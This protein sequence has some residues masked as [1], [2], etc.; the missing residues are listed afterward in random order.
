[1]V[2]KVEET[3]TIIEEKKE[4]IVSPNGENQELRTAKFLKSHI[5]ISSSNVPFLPDT[6]WP[7]KVLFKGWR[8]PQDK[9]AEWVELLV[10]KHAYLWN[11][12]GICDAILNSTY[13]I[14]KHK[15]IVLG[16]AEKW[17]PETNTF[18]FLWGEATI[19]LEDMLILGGFSV[20]GEPVTSCLEG[21]LVE[22]KEKLIKEQ[23]LFNKEKSKKA[24]YPGWINRFMGSN[25]E[26]EHVA[27]LP[28]WMSRYVFPSHPEGNIGK[29][30]FP[31]AI[32]L[33]RGTCVALAPAVLSSLYKQLRLMKEVLPDSTKSL[34]VWGPFQIVQLWDWEHF[35]LL[36]PDGL[37]PISPGAPRM[38]QWGDLKSKFKLSD[39]RTILNS[40]EN[41][42]WRPYT[43]DL[44][45]WHCP[46][47]YKETDELLDI[48]AENEELKSFPRCL[49]ACELVGLQDT[50]EQY[51]P[52]RV[53]MQ[54]GYDQ[55]I[56]GHFF[57]ENATW[58]LAWETYNKPIKDARLYARSRLFR[59]KVSSRYYAWWKKS[60]S[61]LED[62]RNVVSGRS[63]S[64]SAKKGRKMSHS[65]TTGSP[66]R[67]KRK[68]RK[69]KNGAYKGSSKKSFMSTQ[70]QSSSVDDNLPRTRILKFTKT[71]SG[72]AERPSTPSE[73]S[74]DDDNDDKVP[75]SKL[76][77]GV[78]ANDVQT[79]NAPQR[80]KLKATL[81][82][83]N[84]AKEAKN[85]D[86]GDNPLNL[87]GNGE[88]AMYDPLDLDEYGKGTRYDP[89]DADDY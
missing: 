37:N 4:M 87:D 35:L 63:Q 46:S 81:V 67:N 15:D 18:V 60:I 62:E 53:A 21:E 24:T 25:C 9:W 69:S 5:E 64:E 47:F 76:F 56:P 32:H 79:K 34:K 41:F 42:Q 19:T 88:G 8:Q 14:S 71:K 33:S 82:E 27:F 39:V 7:S 13:R 29:H 74:R 2:D 65:C 43:S 85:G 12:I 59:S 66:S 45:N 11:Q 49:V 50:I 31:V 57:R 26:L 84:L 68:L 73:N 48:E 51:L 44:S 86:S 40:L 77:P 52:F 1:M 70:L 54:F 75:L 17:C 83:T 78:R 28:L 30:V 3:N 72:V 16:L 6:I 61:D 55:D 36:R 22:M 89:I 20:L 23:K 80:R 10:P 38:A 58:E